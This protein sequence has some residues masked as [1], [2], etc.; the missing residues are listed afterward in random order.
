MYDMQPGMRKG[1]WSDVMK[2][3]VSKLPSEDMIAIA[4]YLASR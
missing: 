1:I 2:P 3:V 4:A